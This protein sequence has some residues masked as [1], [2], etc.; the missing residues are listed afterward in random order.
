MRQN[1]Y[2]FHSVA[3]APELPI[4]C[5]PI[6]ADLIADGYR[7][8]VCGS[9]VDPPSL[10]YLSSLSFRE[11]LG[12][13]EDHE[14]CALLRFDTLGRDIHDVVDDIKSFDDIVLVSDG[15]VDKKCGSFGWILGKTNGE[16]LAQGSG[17]VF[18]Y[19]PSSYRSEISGS[20]HTDQKSRGAGRG[21]FSYVT[22]MLTANAKWHKD[23]SASIAI[24]SVMFP[25]CTH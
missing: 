23:V 24:T 21:S 12:R 10:P 5:L 11:Y 6:D 15:G 1:V 18:G 13:Q 16:R 19:D 9:L 14:S 8:R 7:I 3:V 25:N 2:S 4:D 17:S 22:L 20:H